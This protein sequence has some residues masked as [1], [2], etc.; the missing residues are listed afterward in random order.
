MEDFWSFN[1]PELDAISVLG[2]SDDP[3]GSTQETYRRINSYDIPYD[4]KYKCNVQ[5]YI[6]SSWSDLNLQLIFE[7]NMNFF[8]LTY[9]DGLEIFQQHCEYSIQEKERELSAK[10]ASELAAVRAKAKMDQ[11][12]TAF[13][14]LKDGIDEAIVFKNVFKSDIQNWT[15]FKDWL[16]SQ[17]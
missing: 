5:L 16:S 7:K 10:I 6:R 13:N 4:R 3:I 9:E 15:E 14:F 1:I 2:Y 17:S 12:Q 8:N 11:F